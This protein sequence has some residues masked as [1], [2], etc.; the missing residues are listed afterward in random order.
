MDS[1][2]SSTVAAK[3]HILVVNDDGPPSQQSSPYVH[4]LV[5]TLQDAGHVVSV[6]LPHTQRSWI[7]KAHMIGQTLKPTYFRPGTLHKD[8]GTTHPRPLPPGSEEQEEWVLV[9]GTP[10]SCVQ[11]GLYHYF[12]DRGPIDL[13]V[14]GPNYG[15]NSTAV[16]GL[17]S[18][19]VG[20][21]LEAA[22][23]KRKAIALSYAFLSR[24]HD[25][26]IIAGASALS[27][28]LIEYLYKNW[29]DDVDLYTIN[30]PLI[31]QVETKKVMWTK[32][33]QNY[34]GPGSCFEE[35]EDDSSD[36]EAEEEKIRKG[37][38]GE[39]PDSDSKRDDDKRRHGHK[40][41][42]WA[43]RFTDVYKSVEEAG[44]GND[45]WIV[46]EGYTSVTPLKANFQHAAAA[47]EGELKLPSRNVSSL[48]GPSLCEKSPHM[49]A[50]IDYEDAYVQPLILEAFKK[51]LPASSYTLIT[52]IND[53]PS[54][55]TPFLQ[56]GAY[57][58]L[59]FEHMMAY[60]QT[61]MV[62][63]Y[64]IRKALI[65]K[66]YLSATAYNW[67][68]K[69]PT[70]ILATNTKPSCD[71][72]LDYA[73]FLDDA[74][75]EA[76]ELQASFQKNEGKEPEEREWW[77]LKPGMSDRG[78]GIR[79]FSTE[80]ELQSIFEEWEA[81]APDS[82]DDQDEEDE[83]DENESAEAITGTSVPKKDEG[84]DNYI[85][86]SHLR[87]FIAQPYIHPPLLLPHN[88]HKFHIR[89]YVLA[90]AFLRIHVYRPML[91]LF[92][93]S[94]YVPPHLSSDLSAHLTNTCLQPT[95][96]NGSVQA[97][98]DLPLEKEKLEGI[99]G[100]I[101]EVTGEVFEAAARGMMVHFQTM[102]NAFEVFGVD[103]LVDE[104]GTAWLLEV[105]AFPDFRQ[106][107]EEL[108]GLVRGLWEGVVEEVVGKF[109]GIKT[110]DEGVKG[111][112]EMVL[113]RELD[114]GR[115]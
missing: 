100:Q 75:V 105:N 65:R 32:M 104:A 110:K 83:E 89:T 88:Q 2:L 14:S 107:G 49:Y 31:E 59:P 11:I 74:L 17:S 112:G 22:V 12:Q 46:K 20:G 99:F 52:S 23:C 94:P 115:R 50:L 5:K 54:P 70:S 51:R 41:F 56:I 3:M 1:N 43:P 71:F 72:E 82:E 81:D 98:W 10:A 108:R 27:L 62:N 60:P 13:V 114:L 53:L 67:I 21:A 63:A 4:S 90:S 58:S 7:G 78:Q 39:Q 95:V 42:K 47:I 16:F 36:V 102:P 57:E 79:L 86:T 85:V 101:Y 77:I 103:F 92:A 48:K 38:G 44:P 91:A 26:E 84:E 111:D 45:G 33:L 113:V 19:T 97:F 64:I 106:T 15:R 24:N 87:H 66:H 28:Q 8:D 109:F 55:S 73:E 9:D 35:V 76:W 40:H 80:E 30:V 61:S 18:G 96:S 6:C 93:S 69:N 29:A 34:W 37:E 25:P 68:A